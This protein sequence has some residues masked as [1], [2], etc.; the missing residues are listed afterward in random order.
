MKHCTQRAV[1]R[2][3]GVA[4]LTPCARHRFFAFVRAFAIPPPDA[5]LPPRNATSSYINIHDI[6]IFL[7]YICTCFQTNH[8]QMKRQS[9]IFIL[10]L[11]CFSCASQK[12]EIISKSTIKLEGKNTNIRD[13]IE[14]DGYYTD[15][16]DLARKWRTARF[17]Q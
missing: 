16:R 17:G 10:L 9:I 7:F 14:I 15:I 13:L 5:K 4:R 11:S 2:K 8:K 3:R 6:T 12:R 1:W